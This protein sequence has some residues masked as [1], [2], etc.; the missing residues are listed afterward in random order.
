MD[1][2]GPVGDGLPERLGVVSAQALKI[3][4]GHDRG[5]VVAHH[6]AAVTRARPLG[7]K[8]ALEVCVDQPVLYLGARRGI[9]EIDQR[10]QRAECVPES[11]IGEH[12]AR[13]HFAVVGAVVHH[14]ALGVDLVEP[15][16]EQHR[17]VQAAVECA[18]A[19]HVIVLHLYAAQHLVP[20]LATLV[21]DFVKAV[22]G[23]FL[24]I[25]FRLL[26]ADKRGS[27]ARMHLF[28]AACLKSDYR[29][30]V[31]VLHLELSL[32]DLVLLHAGL[33]GE[34]LVEDDHEVVAE[35]VRHAAAVAR[36]VA[37][38]LALRGDDPDV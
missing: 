26:G 19:I 34:G 10:K 18:Q 5:G 2:V 4:I 6:A 9:D 36:R 27:D 13:Q 37:D 31:V 21:H 1:G 8:S 32:I 3:G 7:Q 25:E 20:A 12:V 14:L 23:Q 28:A 30:G 16:R 35:V 17:P 15:A 22:I 38:D 29:A 11:R 24:E 33:I